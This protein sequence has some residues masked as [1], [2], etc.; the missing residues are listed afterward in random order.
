MNDLEGLQESVASTL[1]RCILL[2]QRYE[3]LLKSFITQ[4]ELS[5]PANSISQRQAKREN[6]YRNMTLGQLVK[7]L[8]QDV[9]VS[10][11]MREQADYDTPEPHFGFRLQLALNDQMYERLTSDLSQLVM[12]RNNL[13]HHFI[14]QFDLTNT[15]GCEAVLNEL[16]G[17][18]SSVKDAHN[19]PAQFFNAFSQVMKA[20]FEAYIQIAQ[21]KFTIM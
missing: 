6:K 15:V 2:I 7:E 4:A 5:G 1:G 3:T 21:E 12:T 16:R 17:R 18:Y 19:F 13:V 9:I 11:K 20:A 8:T 10:E 14:E